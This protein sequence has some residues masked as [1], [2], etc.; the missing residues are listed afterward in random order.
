MSN[1]LKRVSLRER[2][3]KKKEDKVKH[4]KNENK[5]IKVTKKFTRL[6]LLP[7][8][9]INSFLVSK[10]DWNHSFQIENNKNKRFSIF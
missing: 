6:Y 2:D 4:D 1:T 9:I 5:F 10:M 7:L 3:K 8:F